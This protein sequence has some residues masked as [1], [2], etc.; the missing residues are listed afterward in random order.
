MEVLH[1][2]AG[3]EIHPDTSAIDARVA[4]QSG[5]GQRL[6]GGGGGELA[7]QAGVRPAAVRQG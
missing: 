2:L 1:A 5:H 4:E 3:A 6:Q 7:V